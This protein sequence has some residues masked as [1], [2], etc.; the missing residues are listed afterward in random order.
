M[1]RKIHKNSGG[2]YNNFPKGLCVKNLVYS[3]FFNFT[4]LEKNKCY[5]YISSANFFLFV[6]MDYW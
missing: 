4:V 1:Y 2:V 3:W 6:T 5:H